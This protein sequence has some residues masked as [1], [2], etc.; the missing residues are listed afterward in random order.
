MS[1]LFVPC[2]ALGKATGD[3]GAESSIRM[4]ESK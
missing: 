4:V 2:V 3:G 1:L